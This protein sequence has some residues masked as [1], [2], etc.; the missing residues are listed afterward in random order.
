MLKANT[1]SSVNPDA[2]DAGR[3]AA[4][5]A[6]KNIQPPK[7]IIAHAS[8]EYYQ[9]LNDLTDAIRQEFP[10][11]PVIGST[12]WRGVILPQG[13]VGGRHFV[14][15]LALSDEE[16]TVAVASATNN[17]GDAESAVAAG[18]RAARA[19]LAQAG[20]LDPPD[21]YYLAAMPG[22]EEFYIQGLTEI[23][24]PR[25][26]FG[27]GAMDNP[28]TGD[29][30]IFTDQGVVGYGLAVAFFYTSRP[31]VNHFTSEP[32]REMPNSRLAARMVTPRR[33]A[34]IGGRSFL[35]LIVQHTGFDP[36][37]LVHG[38]VQLGTICDP[39]GVQDQPDGQISLRFPMNLKPDGTVD[40]GANL[41][42]GAMT[43]H[44]RAGIED[45]VLAGGREL[46]VLNRRLAPSVPAAYHLAMGFGRG[47]VLAGEER[48]EEMVEHIRRAAAGVPFLGTFSLSESGSGFNGPATNA[49]LMLS[50]TAFPR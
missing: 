36:E 23:I 8:G 5:Q 34:A 6:K 32:Y 7:I 1:G 2:G 39:I 17:S 3:E 38:D 20:R 44:M 40:L 12:S 16:L 26:M 37:L 27:V 43:L 10:G 30:D 47:L 4:R 29:W 25:P 21:Y 35:D 22:F 41:A 18:R 42:E 19:A 46:A 31:M 33:L 9:G 13:L 50:Y 45:L 24:G 48:L 14:G 49:N 15:L 28:I 11:V